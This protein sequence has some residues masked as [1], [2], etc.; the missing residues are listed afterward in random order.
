MSNLDSACNKAQQ[1]LEKSEADR[2]RVA[3]QE[4]DKCPDCE[5]KDAK[6][7]RLKAALKKYG[8]H[9]DGCTFEHTYDPDQAAVIP[10]RCTCGLDNALKGGE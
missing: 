5:E 10:G 3:E 6:I 2:L 4:A 9:Q 1:F 8:S 7:E